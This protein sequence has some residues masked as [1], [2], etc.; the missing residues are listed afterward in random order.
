VWS[1]HGMC[2]PALLAPSD[3]ANE[4]EMTE[5]ESVAI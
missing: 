3:G 1:L 4:A 5:K 2:T